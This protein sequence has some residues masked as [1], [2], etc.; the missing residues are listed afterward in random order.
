MAAKVCNVVSVFKKEAKNIDVKNSG[1]TQT[2][3]QKKKI[4]LNKRRAQIVNMGQVNKD[5]EKTVQ[6][7]L[8]F[9]FF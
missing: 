2:N 4:K 5:T 3:K 1:D 6:Y 8:S 9:Y 7:Y